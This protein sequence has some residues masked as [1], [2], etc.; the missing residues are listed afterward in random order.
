MRDGAWK[1]PAWVLSAF[2]LKREPPD[3]W[4]TDKKPY[5]IVMQADGYYFVSPEADQQLI[6]IDDT[7]PS[8]PLVPR[9]YPLTVPKGYVVNWL[10][11]GETDAEALLANYILLIGP[12]GSK[13]PYMKGEIKPKNI[14]KIV[15]ANRAE[16]PNDDPENFVDRDPTK[17][18]ID[19]FKTYTRAVD[20]VCNF[21]HIFVPGGSTKMFTVHPDFYA[22]RESLLKEYADHLTDPIKATEFVNKLLKWD[23]DNWLAHDVALGYLK[24][25]KKSLAINRSRV[26]LTFGGEKTL[27]KQG[28]INFVVSS[29]LDGW[30]IDK[31]DVYFN[32]QRQGS[33]SRGAETVL[34]GTVVKDMTTLAVHA[35]ITTDDCGSTLGQEVLFTQEVEK[36][37]I[38]RHYIDERTKQPVQITDDNK[39]M[40]YGKTLNMRVAKWCKQTPGTC[41]CAVCC[42]PKLSAK[43]SGLGA[44]IN[45]IGNF[46]LEVY[47]GGAHVKELKST[48]FDIKT[49]FGQ[50]FN[51]NQ[52]KAA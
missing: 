38:G 12:F 36:S 28:G 2:C 22:Y 10:E 19:E 27:A 8:A 42:G 25:S 30:D 34:G 49:A 39:V 40:L 21:N 46:F 32:A 29:L 41:F 37:W 15:V 20:Y 35:K 23:Y 9:R 52:R 31:V 45:Q 17:F 43:R 1:D 18:Y 11:G 3:K 5:R 50:F 16:Y 44:S 33:F 13:I 14:E 4:Q 48:K 47:M 24:V 26:L 51:R 7:D 6:K